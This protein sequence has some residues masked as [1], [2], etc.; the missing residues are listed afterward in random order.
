MYTEIGII[1]L[2]CRGG[3]RDII[4]KKRLQNL[5]EKN[6]CSS[7]Q[8]GLVFLNKAKHQIRKEKTIIPMLDL[9]FSNILAC[10]NTEET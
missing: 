4:L 3:T 10:S 6:P 8:L 5:S 7:F 2:F 9:R 1:R